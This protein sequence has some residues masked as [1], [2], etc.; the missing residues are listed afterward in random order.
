VGGWRRR[1]SPGGGEEGGKEVEEEE[2]WALRR[3]AVRTVSN[4]LPPE[5]DVIPNG[6]QYT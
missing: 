3:I 2:K 1:R 4:V 6:L 5:T